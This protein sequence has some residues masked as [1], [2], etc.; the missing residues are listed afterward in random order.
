MYEELFAWGN[1]KI[2]TLGTPS[3]FSF[4][5]L[6]NFLVI[7]FFHREAFTTKVIRVCTKNMGRPCKGEK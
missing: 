2:S 4:I 6:S 7:S 3:A 1:K 5:W